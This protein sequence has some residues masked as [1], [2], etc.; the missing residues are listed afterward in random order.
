MV[1]VFIKHNTGNFLRK[2]DTHSPQQ[3]VPHTIHILLVGYLLRRREQRHGFLLGREDFEL[4]A[5]LR[6]DSPLYKV[7][8]YLNVIL[9]QAAKH[10]QVGDA[11]ERRTIAELLCHAMASARARSSELRFGYGQSNQMITTCPL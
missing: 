10:V 9:H 11:P 3:L 2:D 1:A 7:G 8:A 5:F 6:G 4:S